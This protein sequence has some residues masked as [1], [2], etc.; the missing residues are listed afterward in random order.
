M[1]EDRRVRARHLAVDARVVR[2]DDLPVAVD[3]LELF[4]VHLRLARVVG[5]RLD[6]GRHGRLA[7]AVGEGARGDIDDVDAGLCCLGVGVE[8]AAATLVAVQVNRQV[9]SILEGRDQGVGRFWLQEA[10]HILDG[11]DVG[12]GLFHLLGEIR[13]VLQR[14]LLAAIVKDIA[15]VAEGRLRELA[16]LTDFV[17][18]QRHVVELVQAVE[19]AE[20]IDAVLGREGEELAHDFRRIVRVADGVGAARQHLEQD[21]RRSLAHLAQALPRVLVE[22]TVGDIERRAA[23]VLKGVDLRDL[24]GRVV[25]GLHDVARADARGEQGLMGIAVRRVHQQDL[26][27]VLDPLGELL[28]AEL[29]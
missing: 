7:R 25:D 21:V 3:R 20:D 26:L 12:T 14:V 19:D 13:V 11:D 4:D 24:A 17:N 5:E 23:P 16:L 6:E 10:G 29:L 9:D 28:G 18:R 27:L 22:E 1:L 8:R 15:R 2:A